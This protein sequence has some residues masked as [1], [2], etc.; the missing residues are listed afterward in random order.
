MGAMTLMAG[1]G[2]NKLS[3]AGVA[4]SAKGNDVAV[5]ATYALSKRTTAYVK[6]GTF[7][8][9]SATVDAVTAATKTSR[10]SIGLRH[11]F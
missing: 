4:Q 3:V 2:S 8:K 11:T 7:N 5:G 10:T 1:V 6:T 9:Y